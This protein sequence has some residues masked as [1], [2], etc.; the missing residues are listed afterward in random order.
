MVS[1][2][3]DT[4]RQLR[5]F[6]SLGTSQ[7]EARKIFF[8]SVSKRKLGICLASVSWE[9]NAHRA[10]LIRRRGRLSGLDALLIAAGARCRGGILVHLGVLIRQLLAYR[11]RPRA[12][13]AVVAAPCDEASDISKPI[14]S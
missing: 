1:I 3:S 13:D 6:H 5:Q 10:P 14:V 2:W 4:A 7:M 8:Y 12:I 11:A 9:E